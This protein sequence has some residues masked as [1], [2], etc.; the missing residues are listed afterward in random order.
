MSL[1]ALCQPYVW[2]GLDMDDLAKLYNNEVTIILNRQLQT[3]TIKRQPRP[4][5]RSMQSVGLL[6]VQLDV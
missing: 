2:Q 3:R 4:S 6:S 1:P 5:G